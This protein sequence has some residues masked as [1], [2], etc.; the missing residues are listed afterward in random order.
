VYSVAVIVGMSKEEFLHKKLRHCSKHG[1]VSAYGRSIFLILGFCMTNLI[2][3]RL[4]KE[5]FH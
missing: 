1:I 3:F 4:K 2:K 5:E